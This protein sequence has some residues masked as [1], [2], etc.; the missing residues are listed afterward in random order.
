MSSVSTAVDD[1]DEH[2]AGQTDI[3]LQHMS[4]YDITVMI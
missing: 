3:R 1:P 2:L 4:A